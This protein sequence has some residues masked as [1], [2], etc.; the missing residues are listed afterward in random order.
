MVPACFVASFPLSKLDV[1]ISR[2]RLRLVN[3]FGITARS[4]LTLGPPWAGRE[5]CRRSTGRGFVVITNH[6]YETASTIRRVFAMRSVEIMIIKVAVSECKFTK[7]ILS[8]IATADG[9]V[10]ANARG[11]ESR[12]SRVSINPRAVNDRTHSFR[13]LV[14]PRLTQSVAVAGAAIA[15]RSRRGR[16]E[17][18]R[19]PHAEHLN[20]R[21]LSSGKDRRSV[22]SPSASFQRF[23]DVGGIFRCNTVCIHHINECTSKST[24]PGQ[25][26]FARRLSVYQ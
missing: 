4:S 14:S 22:Y 6:V 18:A 13:G 11:S 17:R 24:V 20:H 23:L 12:Y 10:R 7:F 1:R 26:R 3:H 5:R 16:H 21:I 8:P 9:S 25:P 2:G 19:Q 15:V